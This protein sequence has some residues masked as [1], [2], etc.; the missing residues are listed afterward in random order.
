MTHTSTLRIID[1]A[2]EADAAPSQADV[3]P[4]VF[5][6]TIATPPGAPWD[7][8]RAAGLEARVGAPLPLG[9]V[10]YR[11]RRLDNW[12]PGKPGR[13]VALYLRA[14]DL[15]DG[16]ETVVPVDGRSVRVRFHSKAEQRRLAR[17]TAVMASGA[18]LVCFLVASAVASALAVHGTASDRLTAAEQ[19]ATARL[20]EARLNERLKAQTRI[21]NT[22]S[23]KGATVGDY[24]KDLAWATAAKAPDAHIDALHWQHGYM[25]VE[26]RGDMPPFVA[27]DRAIIKSDKPVR[28]GVWL[29]GVAPAGRSVGAAGP[30]GMSGAPPGSTARPGS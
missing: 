25:G 4:R 13:Y 1:E 29:W 8:A 20:H 11:L 6:R 14:R 9:E 19:T 12:S 7:Q 16:L 22:L 15:G 10:I 3:D 26:V 23:A 18:V 5:S 28:T 21:L 2:V 17:R 24:L 27:Q 30:A